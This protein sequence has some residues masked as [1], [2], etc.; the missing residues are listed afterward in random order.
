M[1]N[2]A[3]LGWLIDP[4]NKRVEVY[5]LGQG[6]EVWENPSTLSGEEISPGFTLIL[7]RIWA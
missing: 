3:Q 6:V 1:D 7:K 5:R 4:K 2:G